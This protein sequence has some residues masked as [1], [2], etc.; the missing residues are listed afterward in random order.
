MSNLIPPNRPGSIQW[1]YWIA[2]IMPILCVTTLA[3]ALP[4]LLSQPTVVA[5][6]G[7]MQEHKIQSQLRSISIKVLARGIAIGSGVTIDRQEQIYT[8]ITNAHVLQSSNAPFQI[9]TPDGKIYAATLIASPT[10]QNRDLSILRFQ[11]P[12][13]IYNNAS[14]ASDLPKIG[15]RVWSSG[16]PLADT[17]PLPADNLEDTP[18]VADWGLNIAD[19]Q[20]THILPTALTGGYN[21]GSNNV[22]KKGMSGG[23]LVDRQGKLV[24]INGVHADPLWEIAETLENGATVSGELQ[25]QIDHFSWAIPIEFVKEYVSL[26]NLAERSGS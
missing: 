25:A 26:Q 3:I 16:F 9:Q 13:R 18:S 24:G 21:I 7:A 23:P 19:G 15:D 17:A 8:V 2:G 10:G 11:S 20:I 14:L 6:L 4:G 5:D 12:D 1:Q 22:I